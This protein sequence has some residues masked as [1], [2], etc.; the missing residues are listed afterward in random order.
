MARGFEILL[1][2][3][4][5]MRTNLNETMLG[6]LPSKEDKP[7][8]QYTIR[9]LLVAMRAAL[10]DDRLDVRFCGLPIDDM[11]PLCDS[12]EALPHFLF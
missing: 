5:R 12:A 8:C 1:R 10:E 6:F 2:C 4:R 11:W 9:T 3:P 7:Q